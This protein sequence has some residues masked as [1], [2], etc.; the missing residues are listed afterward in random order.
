MDVG[1][2]ALF[3]DEEQLT[4]RCLRT[5]AYVLTDSQAYSEHPVHQ[6][7]R[8]LPA[9]ALAQSFS[10]T[11]SPCAW[12]ADALD[13]HS[14]PVQCYS[15]GQ[16]T[17]SPLLCQPLCPNSRR[18]SSCGT[19]SSEERYARRKDVRGSLRCIAHLLGPRS[20]LGQSHVR[21][22]PRRSL[23]T[24]SRSLCLLSR[25]P[26]YCLLALAASV[27]LPCFRAMT[28]PAVEPA[29]DDSPAAL[30]APKPVDSSVT[31]GIARSG[32]RRWAPNLSVFDN[33]GAR[34]LRVGPSH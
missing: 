15:D 13:A 6:G 34:P 32:K 33:L 20:Y 19:W 2:Y 31:P 1:I 18:H 8:P 23:A 25:G 7:M 26:L 11:L 4:V 10:Q 5:L 29:E 24:E 9:L 12:H 27:H 28:P 3:D 17:N 21:D 16:V 14:H 22:S 30:I